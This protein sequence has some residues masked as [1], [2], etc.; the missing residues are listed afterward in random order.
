MLSRVAAISKTGKKSLQLARA[1]PRL[2]STTNTPKSPDAA[3]DD[4]PS[5]SV[6]EVYKEKAGVSAATI[7]GAGL[8]ATLLSKEILIIHEETLLAAVMGGTI[9]F[10]ARKFGKQVGEALDEQSQNI[11]DAMNEGRNAR[12]KAYEEAIADEKSV[13][14]VYSCRDQIYEV[15]KENNSMKMELEY[16]ENVNKVYEEVKKRLDFQ[17][18]LQQLKKNLEQ[19]HIVSWL[20]NVVVKSIT[21]QQEKDALAQCIKDVKLLAVSRA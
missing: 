9:F 20:E 11:L 14:A 10:L 12:I 5:K 21:P 19:E 7:F 18:E 4:P 2:V 8:T 16:R 3:V 6:W 1:L 13:E 15:L 17:V